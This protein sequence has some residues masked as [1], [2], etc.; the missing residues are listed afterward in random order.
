MDTRI[1]LVY[2]DTVARLIEAANPAQALRHCAEQ[3]FSIAPAKTKE[4]A[5]HMGRGVKVEVAGETVT[6]TE[7]AAA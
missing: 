3:R 5:F 6:S 4:I 7:G 1:Y 2:E